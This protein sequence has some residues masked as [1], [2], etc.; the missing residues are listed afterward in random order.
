MA[1]EHYVEYYFF[2]HG[3][4][5][6]IGDIY[7]GFMEI[8][9]LATDYTMALKKVKSTLKEATPKTLVLKKAIIKTDKN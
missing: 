7:E 8:E 4:D 5:N 6:K 2:F 9:V 1:Q 3:Y